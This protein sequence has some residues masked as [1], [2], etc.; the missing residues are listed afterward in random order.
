[1]FDLLPSTDLKSSGLPVG[2]TASSSGTSA[3]HPVSF[4]SDFGSRISTSS[5]VLTTSGG[6]VRNTSRIRATT[7]AMAILV[8]VA[9]LNLAPVLRLSAVLGEVAVAVTVA[10]GDV[11]LYVHKHGSK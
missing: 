7:G 2:R 6:C 5:V 11:V 3:G 1:M 4:G 10:A 9:A 8:A